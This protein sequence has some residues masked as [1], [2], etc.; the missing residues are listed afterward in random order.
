MKSID[1][2]NFKSLDASTQQ[3]ILAIKKDGKII[4]YFHPVDRESQ[5]KQAKQELDE[6]MTKILQ[7]TGLTEEEFIEVFLEGKDFQCA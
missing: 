2:D 3:E 6:V 7:E 1:I 5:I 4:G